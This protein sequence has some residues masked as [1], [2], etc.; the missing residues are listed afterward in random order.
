MQNGDVYVALNVD[1]ARPSVLLF[2]IRSECKC[3]SLILADFFFFF[4]FF[5]R[6]RGCKQDMS[7]P[8]GHSIV[9]L[10]RMVIIGP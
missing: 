10:G 2:G 5:F 9:E 3:R 7:K 1:Y 6:N 8:G 4:F